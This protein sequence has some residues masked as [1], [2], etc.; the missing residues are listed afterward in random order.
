MLNRRQAIQS[1]IAAALGAAFGRF[2]PSPAVPAEELDC[3]PATFDDAIVFDDALITTAL[4]HGE[5]FPSVTV[6]TKRR[7]D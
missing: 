7:P 3:V 4:L 5:L 6:T 1:T 2:V